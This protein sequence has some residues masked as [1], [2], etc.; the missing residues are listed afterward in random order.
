MGSLSRTAAGY[1]PT[2]RTWVLSNVGRRG[3]GKGCW[4]QPLW[5]IILQHLMPDLKNYSVREHRW[6]MIWQRKQR[7]RHKQP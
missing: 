4:L 5:R 6:G 7:Q 1:A 2:A 3:A